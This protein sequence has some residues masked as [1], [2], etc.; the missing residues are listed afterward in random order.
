MK[1]WFNF[2]GVD[3]KGRDV[4]GAVEADTF[5]DADA[6]VRQRGVQPARV[7]EMDRV[8]VIER[9]LRCYTMGWLSLVPLLGIIAAIRGIILYQRV[10]MEAGREWNPAG[11][12]LM[13]GFVLAWVGS[14]LSILTAG[15]LFVLL[16]K[17]V[18]G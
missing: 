5:N 18:E 12:Y 10:R 13:C 2:E 14:L 16:I 4:T 8:R 1:R 15:L 3:G 17:L 9:S 7:F 11:R 6:M